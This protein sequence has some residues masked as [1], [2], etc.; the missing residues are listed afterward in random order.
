MMGST[1]IFRFLWAALVLLSVGPAAAAEGGS[2]A[3]ACAVPGG[4][5]VAVV[6][7]IDGDTLSLADGRT[8]H[9]AGIEAVKAVSAE[10]PTAQLAEAAA[11][12]IGS[13]VGGGATVTVSPQPAVPDRYGRTHADVQSADGRSPGEALV[14][15]GLARVRLFPGEKPCLAKLLAAEA[16]ARAAGRGLWALPI[17]AVRSADDPS[18]LARSGLYGLV[19]GR[20]ASVGH[21][22]RLV[23]LDFGPDYR[24][25]FTI[26]VPMAMV[27]ELP[28]PVDALKD[29]RIRVR[30][31]IE[32]SGGPAIRL[33][34]P[35]D[36]EL[37]DGN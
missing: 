26:M 30:G 31:V 18:L 33:G 3:A 11:R 24:S 17:F 9:I 35:S 25:D 16:A 37:L 1:L 7:V 23:F 12:E 20:I 10:A 36:I 28:V 15:A 13:L 19:E 14:M 6:K 22:K 34:A 29:R 21:G 5:A 27:G 4:P 2:G 8:V 32:E